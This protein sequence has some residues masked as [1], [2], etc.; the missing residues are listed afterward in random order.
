VATVAALIV[1][2][3]EETIFRGFLVTALTES[4]GRWAGWILAAFIY[5]IAHFLRVPQQ[6]G[7]VH[8]WSGA[9]GIVSIFGGL[10]QGDFLTGRFA[11]LFLVGLIL[12]GIFLRLGKLWLCAGLHG[13]WIFILLT[14]SALTRPDVPPRI[15]WL[16]GDLL[17]SPVTSLVLLVLGGFLWRFCPPPV[18]D[19]TVE[20]G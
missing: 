9:T 18:G 17:G 4:I 10:F 1:P 8:W 11:N 3:L 6:A 12:G 14:F 7:P 13:G 2:L 5:A 16:G 15:S 20:G 19:V